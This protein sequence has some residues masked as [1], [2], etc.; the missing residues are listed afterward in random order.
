MK[1]AILL[2]SV[3]VCFSSMIFAQSS[4]AK[5]EVLYFKAN[6]ACCK[7]KACNMVESDI[8]GIL[9][10]NFADSS[11]ILRE[12]KL[13]DDANKDL[14]AKYKAQ[15]QTVIIR[16]VTKKKE[17]SA[18]VSDLVKSYMLDQNKENLEKSLL[19]KIS[20]VKKKK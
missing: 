17:C 13:A 5:V 10:K 11:V 12:I 7:A 15:S 3:F 2:L 14:V 4:K 18:D 8:T 9:Q 20:E 1:K 6:L 19:A 16:K